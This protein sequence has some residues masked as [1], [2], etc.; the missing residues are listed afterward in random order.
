[1]CKFLGYHLKTYLTY[2]VPEILRI[3][4]EK[5]RRKSHFRCTLVLLTWCLSR[6]SGE[7]FGFLNSFVCSE[8]V[9]SGAMRIPPSG[10]EKER[11]WECLW[12]KPVPSPAH[13]GSAREILPSQP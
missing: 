10:L 13:Q 1:M 11:R 9:N 6:I 12:R 7:Q 5:I 2:H 8:R 3:Y 4:D